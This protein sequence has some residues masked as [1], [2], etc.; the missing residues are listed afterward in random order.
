MSDFFRPPK[1]RL[2]QRAATGLF[3]L[4]VAGF[5][6]IFG[7]PFAGREIA[8]LGWL[9]PASNAGVGGHRS[10]QGRD[11]AGFVEYLAGVWNGRDIGPVRSRLGRY[12]AQPSD[13]VYV[14]LRERGRRIAQVWDGGN[15]VG[16]A[17]TS[18][19]H[20]LQANTGGAGRAG[21]GKGLTLEIDVTYGYTPVTGD[22][23]KSPLLVNAGRGIYGLEIARGNVRAR[24]APSYMLST[25]R[26]FT[27]FID[28]FRSKHG[29]DEADFA[30]SARL[31]VFRADQ[32][33]VELGAAPQASLMLRGNRMIE[34]QAVT[35]PRLQD[36]VKLGAE[37]LINNTQA[38]GRMVY[39]YWPSAGRESSGNNMI[40]QWMATLAM[41]QVAARISD[42][43]LW[44]LI[45]QN[46]DYNLEHFYRE[47]DGFGLIEYRGQVSLG[48]MAL[49]ALALREHPGGHRWAAKEAAL[50]ATVAS[51]WDDDG[52]FR[53][54]YAPQ[55][56][57][58]EQNFYPG[59]ALLLW[60]TVIAETHDRALLDKFMTSFRYYRS[61]HLDPAHRNPAFI[62]W[63][64]Q[65]YA[66]VWGLT[67]DR[68]LLDFIFEM[69]D[70][71]L[72]MQQG[73]EA[74]PSPEMAGR[75]YEPSGR[76]GPPHASSDGVYLEGLAEAYKLAVVVKDERRQ[77]R[78]RDAMTKGLRHVLQLQFADD[79]DMYYVPDEQKIHVRGGIRTTEYDNRIRCDNVQ[80]NVVAMIK[81]I[82]ALR[83]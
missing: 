10:L 6:V 60:A 66:I 71:L 73:P 69:N 23:G 5:I 51:L 9:T 80:H 4:M 63:H 21:D 20:R 1:T 13:G 7:L 81:A 47:Q 12:L 29:L 75:F 45:A 52:S 68:E 3:V 44:S 65:A 53:T 22:P 78:Y 32:A 64:T 50:E 31:R 76:F 77:S 48:S 62:P 83:D 61:W 79:I 82:E 34:P 25:N 26:S 57:N 18:A 15:T 37:W 54:F 41:E 19:I 56:R 74:V 2:R 35:V 8:S 16:A 39:M 42:R 46:I 11:M 49:A 55:G 43:S 70:W 40:R 67:R 14:A 24:Y 30:R 58:D 72:R 27:G 36:A 59:E 38:D 17:L 33:L 28:L